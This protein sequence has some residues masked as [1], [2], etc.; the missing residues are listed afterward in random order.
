MKKD[1]FISIGLLLNNKTTIQSIEKLHNLI[2][3]KYNYFE[4]ILLN[5][6][7]DT[8]DFNVLLK[9]LKNIRIIE[10]SSYVDIEVAN[11]I[12]IENCIGD[13]CAIMDLSHDS[14]EDLE[15]M[16]EFSED[17]DVV[18]GK[19]EKKIQSFFEFITSKLFY[20]TI[21]LFTGIKL[22]SMYSDFFVINKKVINFITKNE[23]R[24][25]FLKLLKL[26]NGFSKYEHS[27]MPLAKKSNQR[28]FYEN[29]NFTI[30]V[31]VNYSHRLIRMVTILSLSTAIINLV[32]IFYVFIIY[33]LKDNVA[34]GWASSNIYNSTIY[35]VLFLVLSVMGEYIR[36]IIQNQKNTPFY[37]ITDEK[38]S[39]ALFSEKRNIDNE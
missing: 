5:Y 14:L 19:R 35:F 3:Q 18:V 38:S 10:L 28:S 7:I 20:K 22:N 9:N 36:M 17:Y 8:K 32:Y 37:E 24:V 33:L 15:K 16:L 1:N 13:Y 34:D 25:K 2:N 39:V 30:D 21:S 23:D 31:L 12:L 27:Y 26:N 29:I 4:I 6:E 11:S